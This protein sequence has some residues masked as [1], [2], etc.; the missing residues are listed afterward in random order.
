MKNVF[1]VSLLVCLFVML[2]SCFGPAF[3]K[4]SFPQVGL[5]MT[6]MFD[7][8]YGYA[9]FSRDSCTTAL[10]RDVD[11]LRLRPFESTY[12]GLLIK[13]ET[14]DTFYVVQGFE[15]PFINQ[16]FFSFVQVNPKDT[17][18]FQELIAP[19]G[20]KVFI[21]RPD[22]FEISISNKMYSVGYFETGENKRYIISDPLCQ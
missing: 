5:Y 12:I 20:G 18:Y 11:Y 22:F 2:Q 17:L 3:R 16:K 1:N 9:I 7:D 15:E 6:V 4:Y 10:S 19:G 13:P 8:E 14:P 21:S